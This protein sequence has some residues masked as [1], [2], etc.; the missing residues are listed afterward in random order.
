MSD[1]QPDLVPIAQHGEVCVL[2]MTYPE[3]R[4]AFSSRMRKIL[5]ERFE[6]LMYHDRSCGAIVLTGAAGT[7]CA[8]GDLSEMKQRSIIEGRQVFDEP[9]D[10]MRLMVAGPKPVVAAVEGHAFG[11][12]LSLACAADYIVAS[13]QTRFCAAFIKVGLI[14]DTGILWTLGKRVGA[15]KARE[16]MMLASEVRGEEALRIGLVNQLADGGATLTAAIRVA[17][18]M[19]MRPRTAQA[20]LKTAFAESGASPDAAIRAEIDYRCTLIRD[21]SR[22]RYA[23]RTVS[24]SDT[25]AVGFPPVASG[26]DGVLVDGARDGSVAIL[27]LVFSPAHPMLCHASGQAILQVLRDMNADPSCRAI[28]VTGRG[29]DFCPGGDFPRGSGLGGD[30][31]VIAMRGRLQV[32]AALFREVRRGAKPVLAAVEGAVRGSGLALVAASD[33]VVAARDAS[34][35][36]DATG[37]GLLPDAGLLWSLPEKIGMAKARELLLLGSSLDADAARRLGLA[38]ELAAPGA[39]LRQALNIARSFDSLP[40]VAVA[41]TKAA[42]FGGGASIEQCR[43]LELDLSPLARQAVD[44]LEA[45]NAFM[46]ERK[47]DFVGN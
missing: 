44:H 34:F 22:E 3:R 12:G 35:A 36:C 11:A 13:A 2:T 10:L 37:Q 9:R 32:A 6:H 19:A 46:E 5:L 23:G 39:A 25:A 30:E 17:S 41:L 33:Y 20:Y 18:A 7:F 29:A 40:L 38:S 1:P 43:R 15:G 31:D 47:P 28:I 4:N 45:V 8:G 27:T 26:W 42:L 21:C 14:P 24:G 16:L